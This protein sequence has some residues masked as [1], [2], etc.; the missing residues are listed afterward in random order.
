M[1]VQRLIQ[2]KEEELITFTKLQTSPHS[3]FKPGLKKVF[4]FIFPS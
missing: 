4:I 3:F 2:K 1:A